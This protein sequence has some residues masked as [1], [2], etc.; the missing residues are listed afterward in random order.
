MELHILNLDL[1]ADPGKYACNGTNLEGTISQIV[2]VLH[3]QNCF[4]TLVLLL[5]IVVEALLLITVIFISE[6]QWKLDKVQ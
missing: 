5:G 1:E 3:M 6:K 2:I 4:A